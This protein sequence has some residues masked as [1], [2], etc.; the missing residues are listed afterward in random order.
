M[1]NRK[2]LSAEA[3]ALN[4]VALRTKV[5]LKYGPAQ[6]ELEL[7]CALL[8]TERFEAQ[9]GLRTQQANASGSI[10]DFKLRIGHARADRIG[11]EAWVDVLSKLGKMLQAWNH[12]EYPD[13][14]DYL[15]AA[16]V[17]DWDF[18][19][20]GFLKKFHEGLQDIADHIKPGQDGEPVDTL[21]QHPDPALSLASSE[22]GYW[23]LR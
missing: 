2:S 3:I 17:F 4:E 19:L 20:R 9:A 5:A 1:K 10:K 23:R 14:T 22:H 7:L 21:E 12:Q 13:V 16:V 8:L 6:D 15:L 18:G 11:R